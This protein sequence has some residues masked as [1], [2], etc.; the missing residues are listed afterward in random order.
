MLSLRLKGKWSTRQ[1]QGFHYDSVGIIFP[2]LYS[3]IYIHILYKAS[4]VSLFLA[5]NAKG[6]EINRPKQKDRTTTLLSKNFSKRGRDYSNCKT[7]LDS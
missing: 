5:L 1:R 2:L 7:P 4:K 6:K 3:C